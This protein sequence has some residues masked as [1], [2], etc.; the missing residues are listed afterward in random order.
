MH[1]DVSVQALLSKPRLMHSQSELAEL[2]DT[3]SAGPQLR[4]KLSDTRAL[5][6]PRVQITRVLCPV[7]EML[8][9]ETLRV[10]A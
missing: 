1:E 9:L 3:C 4:T 10:H 8:F 5:V 6:R 2:L 7:S